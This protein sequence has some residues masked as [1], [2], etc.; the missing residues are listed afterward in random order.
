MIILKSLA[1]FF[2]IHE[3]WRS[4]YQVLWQNCRE[5]M[6]CFFC[7]FVNDQIFL[8][9]MAL[10]YN[11]IL[12][13]FLNLKGNKN[14]LKELGYIILQYATNWKEANFGSS[15][16]KF[17]KTKGLRNRDSTVFSLIIIITK[18]WNL[19]GSWHALF[20]GSRE[21]QV[22]NNKLSNDKVSNN[23]VCVMRMRGFL[24]DSRNVSFKDTFLTRWWKIVII[25]NRFSF[26]EVFLEFCYSYD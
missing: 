6:Y 3:W 20:S 23:K 12:I 25:F 21:A 2:K 14:W 9:A 4:S 11:G 15:Y 19:I 24:F 26:P 7:F 16:W 18:L 10:A 22:S 17:R 5:Y 8:S 13:F 1:N